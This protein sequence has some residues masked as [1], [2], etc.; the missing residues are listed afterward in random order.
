M[1]ILLN[2]WVIPLKIVIFHDNYI[3]FN[4]CIPFDLKS[5]F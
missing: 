5:K 1:L 4:A 2:L 3:I